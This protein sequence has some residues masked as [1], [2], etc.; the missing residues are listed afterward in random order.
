LNP[1]SGSE[2]AGGPCGP[3]R[4][5]LHGL[6]NASLRGRARGIAQAP[7]YRLRPERAFKCAPVIQSDQVKNAGGNKSLAEVCIAEPGLMVIPNVASQYMQRPRRVLPERA[8]S[9]IPCHEVQ[10]S[11][12][13]W[14]RQVRLPPMDHLLPR[15]RQV[16][17]KKVLHLAYCGMSAPLERRADSGVQAVSGRISREL[18]QPGAGCCCGSIA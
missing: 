2:R 1:V 12:Q 5:F 15:H 13:K 14:L 4:S 11:G 3:K 10:V 18:P 16:R 7:W 9:S 6:T 17:F 8:T